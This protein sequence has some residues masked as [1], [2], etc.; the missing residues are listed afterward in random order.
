MIKIYRLSD[1]MKLDS[2]CMISKHELYEIS[3]LRLKCDKG[4]EIRI[5][6]DRNTVMVFVI[7][8]RNGQVNDIA[9]SALRTIFP[10]LEMVWELTEVKE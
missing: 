4:Y 9:C 3:V 5:R 1:L 6:M 8:D 7:T 2:L 10:E